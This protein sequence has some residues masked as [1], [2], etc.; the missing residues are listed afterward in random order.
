MRVLNLVLITV[1]LAARLAAQSSTTA[2][3]LKAGTRVRV[4]TVDAPSVLRTGIVSAASVD[5][6]WFLPDGTDTTV[7]LP[8]RAI[9]QLNVSVAR[10][11]NARKGAGI[12]VLV[13]A[14]AGIIIGLTS[15][16][17]DWFT[18]AQTAVIAGITS[19][20]IGLLIGG[21]V[22]AAYDTEEWSPM[23]VLPRASL[24]PR[25]SF[26]VRVSIVMR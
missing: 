17:D 10:H 2:E 5:S 18:P 3:S 26:G 16:G 12:G 13:G 20:A 8:Y 1:L 21:A 23:R 4:S 15:G 24:F 9:A 11:R 25:P 14:G 22:G 6:L 19:G 7:A